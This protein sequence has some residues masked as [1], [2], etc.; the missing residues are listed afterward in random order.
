[1]K[2]VFSIVK[3]IAI[4]FITMLIITGCNNKTVN[5][6]NNFVDSDKVEIENKLKSIQADAIIMCTFMGGDCSEEFEYH[7][8]YDSLKIYEYKIFSYHPM[9]D[10]SIQNPVENSDTYTLKEY[11]I[12]KNQMEEIKQFIAKEENNKKS[13]DKYNDYKLKIGDETY[14]IEDHKTMHEILNKIS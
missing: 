11:D 6:N 4:L 8:C 14:Y 1:M 3:V 9:I 12:S 2:K 10:V 5:P 13:E 7:I